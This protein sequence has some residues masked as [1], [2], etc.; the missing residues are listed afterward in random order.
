MK[1]SGILFIIISGFVVSCK[2][3]SPE[4]QQ[5]AAVK[6]DST[7]YFP[8]N[9]FFIQQKKDVDSTAYFL[10]KISLKDGK[11]DSS[12]IDKNTFDAFASQ[13]LETDISDP[14]LKNLYKE[15]IFEDR[16]T[17]SYTFT[18]TA[19]NPQL[20]VESIHILLN[21]ENER[22]KRV[23]INKR[24]ESKDSI[25]IEKLGWKTDRNLYINRMVQYRNGKEFIEENKIVWN[26]KD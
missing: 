7:A 3:P 26:D 10:Y 17:N 23:F 21:T 12:V 15:N 5:Q 2:G 18:Y 22:V 9:D 8:I 4:K 25:V 14:A 1:V 6:N 20:P 24:I 16:T 13:F 11:K 19:I